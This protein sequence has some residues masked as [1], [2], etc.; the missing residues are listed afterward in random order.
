MSVKE[1]IFSSILTYIF[2]QIKI[3]FRKIWDR[4]QRVI[5]SNVFKEKEELRDRL[6]KMTNNIDTQK[7]REYDQAVQNFIN[8]N[9]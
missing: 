5:C 9:G 2:N 6:D 4:F 3:P 7:A 1:I 8:Y